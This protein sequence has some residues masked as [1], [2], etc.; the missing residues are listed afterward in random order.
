MPAQGQKSWDCSDELGRESGHQQVAMPAQ[1]QK[2]WD[3]GAR[4]VTSSQ[5]LP[6]G[7]NPGTIAPELREMLRKE[8][9]C[10][11]RGRNPGTLPGSSWHRRKDLSQCLPRGRN[12]GTGLPR[13]SWRERVG[14]AMPAQGQKSWDHHLWG[15]PPSGSDGHNACP[16]A[17]ILGPVAMPAQGQKS[18]DVSRAGVSRRRRR[19]ACP[20]AEILGPRQ[21]SADRL[22]AALRNACPGAEILERRNP[23]HRR[24]ACLGAE[25]LGRRFV[26]AQLRRC[27]AGRNACPGAEILG[28]ESQCLPRGRNPGTSR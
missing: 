23:S 14:V 7:G 20:G 2:S 28:R 27:C 21:S 19:N 13:G 9:Q 22:Q 10:L 1:G 6:R 18:W 16:V 15:L 26:G 8:S 25:I 4:P 3:C 24:N 17:E 12:P 5:C 11:P